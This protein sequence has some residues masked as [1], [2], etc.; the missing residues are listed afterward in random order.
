VVAI[1]CLRA[2][3]SRRVLMLLLVPAIPH[4]FILLGIFQ[5]TNYIE[6]GLPPGDDYPVVLLYLPS[7]LLVILIVAIARIS[8]ARRAPP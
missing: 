4:V 3:V 8:R 2:P 6:N 1:V 5:N 7:A